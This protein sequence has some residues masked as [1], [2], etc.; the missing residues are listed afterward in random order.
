MVASQPL[1]GKR[2][3]NTRPSHQSAQLEQ[4]IHD[5]GGV[6][7]NFPVIAINAVDKQY[8]QQQTLNNVDWLMFVSPNAVAC[9]SQAWQQ[10]IPSG[11]KLVAVGGEST[12]CAMRKAGLAVDYV[13]PPASGSDGLIT[14]TELQSL[15][16]QQV[17]IVRGDGGRELL[18]N[19]LAKRGATISYMDVYRRSV[20]VY[21]KQQLKPAF[22]ADSIIS[23]SVSGLDNLIFLLQDQ[24]SALKQKPLIVFS[25]RIRQHA[26]QAGFSLVSVTTDFSDEALVA[27]LI[28][29]E[30]QHGR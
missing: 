9:F 1:A 10:P 27:A 12:A 3:L 14:L 21:T 5:A 28:E 29:M 15:S 8:W 23:T 11:I 4:L 20:P 13:P 25:E 19:T 7:I 6:A 17:V 26:Q 30:K 22:T 2:I 16:G 18:A 24:L